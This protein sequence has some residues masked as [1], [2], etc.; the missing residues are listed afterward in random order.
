[1]EG[2]G[3]KRWSTGSWPVLKNAFGLMA[4]EKP[5]AGGGKKKQKIYLNKKGHAV[6]QGKRTRQKKA[7][8]SEGGEA[9]H[10]LKKNIKNLGKN[11]TYASNREKRLGLL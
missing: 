11:K 4:A 3:K 9:H 6:L 1:V 10:A 5:P 2:G 7:L 8:L